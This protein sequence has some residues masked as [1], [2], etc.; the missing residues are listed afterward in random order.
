VR[1]SAVLACTVAGI[2][3]TG[4]GSTPLSTTD[5]R[6][7]ATRMCAT[8]TTQTAAIPAPQSPAA[9]GA[10]LKRGIAILR[11]ELAGLRAL[12]PPGDLAQVY[13]IS[14]NA[15]SGKLH[16]LEATVRDLGAGGDPVIA[17]KV[18]QQRLAP[19]ESEEDGAWQALQIPACLNS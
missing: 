1:R 8:A 9:S 14:V 7:D 4:C 16:A 19:L 17:M 10:F 3:V 13:S 5:L 11:P 18:L 2:A 12:K 6:A 15:F